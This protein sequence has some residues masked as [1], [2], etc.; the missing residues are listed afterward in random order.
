MCR[1]KRRRRCRLLQRTSTTARSSMGHR[2]LTQAWDTTTWPKCFSQWATSQVTAAGNPD[3]KSVQHCWQHTLLMSLHTA[4]AC[5]AST[6]SAL[7]HTQAPT[8]AA[9]W[10]SAY[11]AAACSSVCWA[12]R[13][14]ASH[15]HLTCHGSF[16]WGC[17]S[18]LRSWR[19]CR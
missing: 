7:V 4:A 9:T 14:T 3:S 10:W 13:S 6:Q 8:A 16:L 19:C 1:A 2:M 11:G 18:W 12:A 15:C 5:Y 17:C